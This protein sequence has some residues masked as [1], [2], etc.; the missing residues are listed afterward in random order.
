LAVH[1][2]NYHMTIVE[3]S[4]VLEGLGDLARTGPVR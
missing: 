1:P 3:R 2:D 4:F